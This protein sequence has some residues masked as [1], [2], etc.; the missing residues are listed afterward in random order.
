MDYLRR[1]E[2]SGSENL[3]ARRAGEGI[4]H[5]ISVDVRVDRQ[6]MAESRHTVFES[7]RV[8]LVRLR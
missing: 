8:I 6:R 2:T 4:L 7:P 1:I 5:F 3:I